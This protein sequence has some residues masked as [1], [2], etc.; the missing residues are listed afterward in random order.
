MI[1]RTGNSQIRNSESHLG[2]AFTLVEL[3]LVMTL[4]LIVFGVALPSL[5]GFFRGRS[6]DSEARR[7]LSLTRYGQSR[8]VSEGVPMVLWID[9]RRGRYGLQ[10]QAGYTTGDSNAVTF[11][12]SEG[13]RVEVQMPA[14]GMGLNPLNQTVAGVGNV[15]MIR[16]T[17]DE[18]IGE[19]SPDRIVFRQGQDDAMWILESTNRL[20]YELQASDS[21]NSRR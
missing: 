21:P 10:Q 3:L 16:F 5:K 12:L 6:L 7:F 11:T 13:V 20:K 18:F 4:L 9:S 19:S 15:P 2:R 8:A 1:L 14:A 17:P